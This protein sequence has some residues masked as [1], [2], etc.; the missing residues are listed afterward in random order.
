[1][2]RTTISLFLKVAARDWPGVAEGMYWS[3][4]PSYSE[5]FHTESSPYACAPEEEEK[6]EEEIKE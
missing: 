3:A 2:L 6:K 1:M 4:T 5:T